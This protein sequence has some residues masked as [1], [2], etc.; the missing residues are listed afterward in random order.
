[1]EPQDLS[2]FLNHIQTGDSDLTSRGVKVR[3]HQGGHDAFLGLVTEGEVAVGDVVFMLRSIE[4][5]LGRE[6]KTPHF[7]LCE[8]PTILSLLT[9]LSS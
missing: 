7:G 2:S 9:Y 1:M 6:V 8:L 4:H 3:T 5:H